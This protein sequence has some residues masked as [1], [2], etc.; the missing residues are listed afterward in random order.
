MSI[1]A[2]P[3]WPLFYLQLDPVWSYL[4][5]WDRFCIYV[6]LPVQRIFCPIFMSG[7]GLPGIHEY[8]AN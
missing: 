6:E 1:D 2:G 7:L 4:T 3:K 8:S 5:V